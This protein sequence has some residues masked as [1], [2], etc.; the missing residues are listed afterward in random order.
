MY[1]GLPEKPDTFTMDEVAEK[2][3]TAHLVG[4][5]PNF[6]TKDQGASFMGMPTDGRAS[7]ALPR[8]AERRLTRSLLRAEYSMNSTGETGGKCPMGF[9]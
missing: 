5:N 3:P 1:E 4:K 8:R 6:F 2:A 9:A 7:S